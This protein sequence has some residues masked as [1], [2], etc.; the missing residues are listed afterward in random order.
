[1]EETSIVIFAVVWELQELREEGSRG[2]ARRS[3][4][5]PD[6]KV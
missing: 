3:Y 5:R 2:Y 1:M 6:R 4:L